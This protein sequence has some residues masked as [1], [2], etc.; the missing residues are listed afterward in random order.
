M[1]T[2]RGSLSDAFAALLKQRV[3]I[4][5]GA[6]GT[7]IQRHRLSEEQFRGERFK[8]WRSDLRGNN[9][10]LVITQPQIIA[11]IHR[12][13]FDA[14]ADVISTNTFNS[15]SVSQA[16]YGMQSV[17]GELNSAAACIARQVADEVWGPPAARLRYR[18]M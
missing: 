12:S 8:T 17:V 10:L 7:M 9:D 16:D 18:P 13:Y 11:D 5:D 6:M 15:T 3:V 14:G 4:F 2:S 1:P